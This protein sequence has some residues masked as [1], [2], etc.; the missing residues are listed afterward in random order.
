MS[1]LGGDVPKRFNFIIDPRREYIYLKPNHLANT[2][3]LS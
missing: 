1:I 2:A 3:Y